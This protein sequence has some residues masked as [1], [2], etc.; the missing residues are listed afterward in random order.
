MSPIQWI[1]SFMI[2]GSP[3]TAECRNLITSEIFI[4]TADEATEYS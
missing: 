3:Y 2:L 1:T 4:L